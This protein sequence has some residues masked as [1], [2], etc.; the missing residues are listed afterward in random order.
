MIWYIKLQT[1]EVYSVFYYRKWDDEK[2]IIVRSS[3]NDCA[4]YD[5]GESL[6]NYIKM[7]KGHWSNI[8][9]QIMTPEEIFL[10]FL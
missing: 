7:N 1:I 8:N 2:D 5:D 3:N 6:E 9:F 4:W 10:E